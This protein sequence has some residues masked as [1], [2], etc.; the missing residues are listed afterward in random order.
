MRNRL[1]AAGHFIDRR[2]GPLL[3]GGGTVCYSLS[4]GVGG[5]AS[6]RNSYRRADSM[7][8]ELQA[9]ES[10]T[11]FVLRCTDVSQQ[12]DGFGSLATFRARTST[13]AFPRLQTYCRS[14]QKTFRATFADS[15]CRAYDCVQRRGSRNSSRAPARQLWFVTAESEEIDLRQPANA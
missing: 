7:D 11:L 1:I 12:S 6:Y 4:E 13:S 3:S 2:F 10:R 9:V 15:H 8:V 5:D 14:H